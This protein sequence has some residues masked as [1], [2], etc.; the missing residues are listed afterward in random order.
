[1]I[2]GKMVLAGALALILGIAS[3]FAGHNN[4]TQ[5]DVQPIFINA[6]GTQGVALSSS[7]TI[8]STP[9]RA[10]EKSQ[11]QTIMIQASGVSPNYSVELLVT[12]DRAIFTAPGTVI[13]TKPE[14]GGTLY[15]FTDALAHVFPLFGPAC[16]G[17]QLRVTGLGGTHGNITAQELSQ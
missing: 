14:I 12:L 11:H 8:L 16:L 15:T 7:G 1:M 17:Q 13:F 4:I 6:Q 5:M 9:F 10:L 2:D 3:A